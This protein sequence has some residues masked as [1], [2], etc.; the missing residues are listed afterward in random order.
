MVKQTSR[1]GA[2]STNGITNVL[3][4][5]R[6]GAFYVNT[7]QEQLGR[8]DHVGQKQFSTYQG[9]FGDNNQGKG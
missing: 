3:S 8:N 9:D 6:S 5:N 4:D 1:Y 7:N 2:K